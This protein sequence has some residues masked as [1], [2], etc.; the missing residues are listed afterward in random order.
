MTET[1]LQL[2]EYIQVGV[3]AL[4]APDGSF[5]PAVPLYIKATT[6]SKA[7]EESITQGITGVLA[8]RMKLYMN[9][10]QQN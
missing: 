7:A 10:T 4:R 9:Q 8:E 5:L 6:E 1:T 2:P 3:T